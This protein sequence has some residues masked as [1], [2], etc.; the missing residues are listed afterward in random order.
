MGTRIFQ[1]T[2]QEAG[3][4]LELLCPKCKGELN[5]EIRTDACVCSGCNR[6]YFLGPLI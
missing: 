3:Q 6:V 5:G 4:V 1:L 2:K